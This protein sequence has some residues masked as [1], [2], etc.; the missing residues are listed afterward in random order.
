MR[1]RWDFFTLLLLFTVS[2]FVFI[3]VDSARGQKAPPTPDP[4]ARI[5]A[6]WAENMRTKQ[7]EKLAMM[8]T[9]DAIFFEPNGTSVMGRSAIRDLCKT[10]MA[11]YTSDL[12]FHTVATDRSGNLAY[13][14]GDY[15]ESLL[16]LSDGTKSE[17]H[18]TYLMVFKRQANGA[19]LIA[20]QVW[21]EAT[22]PSH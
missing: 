6:E 7:L 10:V 2:A 13:D 17:T 8:Y 4:I 9:E 19:W 1:I 21:T 20:Q 15:T 18:G 22:P 11:E 14:S 3:P 16:R 12:T 5:R